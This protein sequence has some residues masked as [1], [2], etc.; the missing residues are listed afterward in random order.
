M[1]DYSKS[2][3]DAAISK[4]AEGLKAKGYEV[5]VVATG[6]EAK[7]KVLEW[8]P[9]G[10]EV[11]TGSSTTL[12]QTGL[13]DELTSDRF[14]AIGPKT[15]KMDRATQGRQIAKLMA[16]PDYLVA[17]VHA[18]TETGEALIAS[19][20]GSQLAATVFGAGTVI[21]VVGSNKIVKDKAEGHR[22][23]NEYVI[24]LESARARKAYGLPDGF[25]TFAGKLVEFN[26][27]VNPS[28]I[29]VVLVKEAFGF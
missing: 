16:A 3:S 20:S 19:M 7:A 27:E 29:K 13:Q 14:D 21:W 5:A 11:L 25:Q 26:K 23:L 9:A 24:D 6:A 12:I 1:S 18:L 4:A 17:S 28:R 10:A 2:A 15:F 22:R 8:I